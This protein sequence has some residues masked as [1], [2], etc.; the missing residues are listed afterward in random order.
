MI[1]RLKAAAVGF[2]EDQA[3]QMGAALAYYTLFSLTPLLIVALAVLG[4]LMDQAQARAN[5]LENLAR[6]N[7][8]SA[9]AVGVMLDSFHNARGRAG[10][11]VVG[12]ASL[13]FGATGM[14]TSLRG[15]LCRVWRL[16]DPSEGVITG[17]AKTYLLA[18]L[19]ILVSCAFLVSLLLVSASLPAFQLLWEE[20]VSR[21][22][23]SQEA[24][25]FAASTLCL[26]LLFLFTYRFLSDGRL[27]YGRLWLGSFVTAILFGVGKV[28]ITQY[29]RYADF[30]SA[31]GTAGS[32][33]VFLAW[34][35]YSAQILFYGAEVIRAGLPSPA[36]GD[37]DPT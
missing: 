6:F 34:V 3:G 5:V 7:P 27:P 1:A 25:L 26:T 11:S 15:S 22:P 13:L 2:A 17:F 28:V 8:E 37:P 10:F 9:E 23:W 14:F 30:Q 12:L 29:L 24:A 32:V 18:L 21:L 35:Y 33:V 19:M 4:M 36:K 31:F 16:S 20:S